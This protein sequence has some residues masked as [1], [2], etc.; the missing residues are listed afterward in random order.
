MLLDTLWGGILFAMTTAITYTLL[1]KD[2]F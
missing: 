1:W 2:T